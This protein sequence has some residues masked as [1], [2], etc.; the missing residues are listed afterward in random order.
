M[1]VTIS[2]FM[3]I[4]GIPSFAACKQINKE[5]WYFIP[6]A[7]FLACSSFCICAALWDRKSFVCWW[8]EW[9]KLSGCLWLRCCSVRAWRLLRFIRTDQSE[10]SAATLTSPP[11]SFDCLFWCAR[12]PSEKWTNAEERRRTVRLC[13]QTMPSLLSCSSYLSYDPICHKFQI[14]KITS[15]YC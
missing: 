5:I 7:S 11:S 3:F 1:S 14:Y 6:Y 9:L 10:R 15:E 4:D 2:N 13:Q 8:G 12:A